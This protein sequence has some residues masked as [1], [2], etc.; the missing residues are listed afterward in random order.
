MGEGRKIL[1]GDENLTGCPT[2]KTL[3]GTLWKVWGKAN[4]F[5]HWSEG[6]ESRWNSEKTNTEEEEGN[7]ERRR[8]K[9][10]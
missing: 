6:A 10:I 1:A 8:R 5:H 9:Q 7:L 2:K 4:W 3:T